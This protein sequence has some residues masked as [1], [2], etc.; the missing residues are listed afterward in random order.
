MGRVGRR[1]AI[2]VAGLALCVTST[3]AAGANSRTPSAPSADGSAT[4]RTAFTAP[5]DPDAAPVGVRRTVT[6]DGPSTLRFFLPDP[7]GP[8]FQRAPAPD[9][10]V[11]EPDYGDTD[12]ALV[13]LAAGTL[14]Q[15]TPI[16]LE[17]EE[18]EQLLAE[19]R[20]ELEPALALT[21][22]ELT[23]EGLLEAARKLAPESAAD[24]WH[25]D[26]GQLV[27]ATGR[28]LQPA[29]AAFGADGQTGNLAD[30]VRVA[31]ERAL[32][33]TDISTAQLAR[34][35][36]RAQITRAEQ[37]YA[38]P[39]R[40]TVSD[41]KAIVSL[42]QYRTLSVSTAVGPIQ[43]HLVTVPLDDPS[44]G[45]T[46]RRSTAWERRA[47]VQDAAAA[48]GLVIAANGGFWTNGGDPDGLL[49][50]GGDLQS[51]TTAGM[52]RVRG[53]RAA[54]G[55]RTD[56][57]PVVG[58]P[59][60]GLFVRT[61]KGTTLI[62]GVN[63]SVGDN[64]AVLFTASGP[65]P[66]VPVGAQVWRVIPEAANPDLTTPG[67]IE[68][69]SQR[70]GRDDRPTDRSY[71]LVATGGRV[72]TA[73][74][75]IEVTTRAGWE[76]L[77]TAL[78]GGPGLVEDGQ[79]LGTSRWRAEGFAATHTDARHPRTA[80]GFDRFGTSFLLVV[81]GRQPGYSVGA[82]HAETAAVMEAFGVTDAVMLDGGGSTQLVINGALVNRPCCD[83]PVRA[84]A[85]VVG[86]S[87]R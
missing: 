66:I 64:D 52:Y 74:T 10:F 76:S 26:P 24:P 12:A 1:V 67:T 22:V 20:R 5:A 14:G 21:E 78:A 9:L 41:P 56:G 65:A 84:V 58:R 87:N 79:R 59:D 77:T 36:S 37:T 43:G 4:W 27:A 8:T 85:T 25:M 15:P 17:E 50:D 18:V 69:Q 30:Q 53:V 42:G 33:P 38:G 28:R 61:D 82:T 7:L 55:V 40:L 11:G 63:R 3:V 23:T 86:F 57:Q 34:L 68:V 49:V 71:L 54:F 2:A 83:T 62:Q 80:I 39:G 46:T 13:N 35:Q 51:D 48:H 45:L 19:A 47:S 75:A 31:L 44:L 81:D 16:A 73:P 70:A 29:L 72:T 6:L 32:L 60:V